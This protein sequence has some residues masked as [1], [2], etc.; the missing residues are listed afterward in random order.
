MSSTEYIT[1]L[2]KSNSD[3]SE[4]NKILSIEN[5]N[6]R[7]A[8]DDLYEHIYSNNK[9]IYDLFYLCNKIRFLNQK[10]QKDPKTYKNTIEIHLH[11]T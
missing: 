8:V 7:Y 6:Y 2:L 5:K 10:L 4:T 3:L 11:Q 1:H 9:K